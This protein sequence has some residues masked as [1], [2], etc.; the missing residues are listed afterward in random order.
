MLDREKALQAVLV[1]TPEFVH[2]EQ[3]NACLKA[4][5]HVYCEKMMAI[6]LDAARSMVRT[7]HQTGKLLQLGYQRHSNPRYRHVDLMLLR[8]AKL[9]GRLTHVSGQWNQ[10]VKDDVGWPRKFAM[11]PEDLKRYGY[12][13][14]H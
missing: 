12:A 4:G 3:S 9:A 10:P 11:R 13:D 7:A 6:S 8:K 1:A 5:L 2:A 14:M